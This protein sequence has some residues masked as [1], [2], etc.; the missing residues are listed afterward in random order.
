MSSY[1]CQNYST[2]PDS[3]VNLHVWASYTYHSLGFYVDL[4]DVALEGVQYLL[5]MHPPKM[6]GVKPWIR[7]KPPW[8]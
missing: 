3:L 5:K 8:P 1:I 2:V 4:K 7:W 6:S